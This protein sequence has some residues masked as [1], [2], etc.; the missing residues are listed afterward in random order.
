[1]SWLGD[2]LVVDWLTGVL[3]WALALIIQVLVKLYLGLTSNE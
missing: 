3:V 2:R 1:M